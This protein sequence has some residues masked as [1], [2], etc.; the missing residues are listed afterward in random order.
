MAQNIIVDRFLDAGEEPVETLTPIAGYETADLV[1]LEDAVKPLESILVNLDAMVQTA[2]RNSRKPADGL[3][4]DESAAIH[5]YTIQ[6]PKPHT[7]LYTLLNQQLRSQDRDTLVPWYLY[8]KLFL[9][10]LYKLPSVKNRTIWRG[11]CGNVSDQYDEDQIWWG[12]SS[13]TETMKVMGRFVGL[14]GVRTLFNIECINGKAIQAHSHY[15]AENEILLMPGTYLQVIDKWSP[16]K[17]L[18]IIH[19][20]ETVAPYQTIAPPFDPCLQLVQTPSIVNIA[21]CNEMDNVSNDSQS[22]EQAFSKSLMYFYLISQ[23]NF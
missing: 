9:T 16:S 1:S 11:I 3:T 17:D 5:L 15:K 22:S 19:L 7:S 14:D 2:K 12:I 10:A 6:W 23:Q 21:I 4:P 20:R 8:L 18:F 13:C